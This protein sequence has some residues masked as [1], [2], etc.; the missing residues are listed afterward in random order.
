MNTPPQ[1]DRFEGCLIGAALG[2]AL[3][4][5]Y[6]FKKGPVPNVTKT[7][8]KGH[9]GTAPGAPTDDSTLVLLLGQSLVKHEGLDPTDYLD[10]LVAWWKT[11][12]P[13]IGGQTLYAASKWDAGQRVRPNE[14]ACGNGSLMASAPIGLFYAGNSVLAAQ[15][16]ED[17]SELTHPS[18]RSK[19]AVGFFCQSIARLV[20]D[21]RLDPPCPA[22]I[23]TPDDFEPDGQGMGYVLLTAGLAYE[24]A[25]A[26]PDAGHAVDCLLELIRLGGDTDTNA[27]VAG[28]LLGARFGK[29]AWPKAMVDKLAL[30]P[31][32]RD[33]ALDLYAVASK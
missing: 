21:P 28:A 8:K 14:N 9:F 19:R 2:D 1:L 5:P 7:F 12:P 20:V 15:V 10:R 4:A 16:G 24:T 13:D 27:T 33:L 22:E 11:G 17:F 29:H 30:A 26:C 25:H 18:S 32:M 3:G 23:R 6:E 31:A